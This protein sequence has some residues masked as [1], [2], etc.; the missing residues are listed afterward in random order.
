M[1][2]SDYL[3]ILSEPI[4]DLFEEYQ[5]SVI[6]DIARR[7]A[8]MN[9]VTPTAAW[10]I[11]RAIEAG[12]TYEDI[13]K[14]IEQLTPMSE[15][16]LNQAF[17]QAGVKAIKFD[18]LIY[19][20]AGLNP[21]PLNLSPAMTNVLAAGLRKTGNLINNLVMTT[22]ETGQEVFVKAADSAYMKIVTGAF[23]YNTAIR[24]SVKEAAREGLKVI[25]FAS[26]RKDQLDV[27]MRRAVLTGVNQTVGE[28]TI[29]R[30]REMGTTLF[31]T[32]AH[33]GARPTHE[34]W[35]GKVFRWNQ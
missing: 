5:K 32:S 26:G 29:S 21:L 33:I 22:A 19:K 15:K 20:K 11:Q 27:S 30:A 35:Q 4:V 12:A 34:V 17:K 2:T 8:K 7:L 3:D 10:Q 9:F 13:L 16:Y 28:L 18:D 1:L 31:Q 24:Q 14:K 6:K 23:D 25:N